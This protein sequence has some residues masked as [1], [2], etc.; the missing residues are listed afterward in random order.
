MPAFYFPPVRADRVLKDGDTVTL[1]NV[2]LTARLTAGHTPGC[3]TWIT[4]VVDGGTV[5]SSCFQ[6][7]AM[8]TQACNSS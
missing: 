5:T 2:T 7:A 8:S 6:E 4:S 3:T 1:G